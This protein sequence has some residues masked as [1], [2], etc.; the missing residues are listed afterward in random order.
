MRGDYMPQQLSANVT[1]QIPENKVIVDKSYLDEIKSR[2]I[3]GRTWGLNEF[4]K[5]CCG[6]KSPEWVRTFILYKFK[7]EIELRGK[8]GWVVI[9]QGKGHKTIIFADRACQWMSEN[10]FRIDWGKPLP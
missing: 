2:N 8:H 1:I 9:G 5:Q 10:S 7:N 4:R 6:N 3:I